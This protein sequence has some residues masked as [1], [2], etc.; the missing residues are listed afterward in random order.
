MA[1]SR[2][3]LADL[4]VF[5][6][7]ARNRS[8][9]RAGAE[10]GLS[11]SALSH[12]MRNLEGRLGVGLLNRNSRS[13]TPTHAG[14]ALLESLELG[15]QHIGDALE[16][17][18]QFREKPTG[19]LRLNVPRDAVDLLLRPVLP[20]YMRMYPEM[21]LEI[22]VDDNFVDIVAGGY[23]A[24][25]RH[26]GTVAE[27]MIAMN[28]GPLLRWI[29]VGAPGYLRQHG[30]PKMPED[31]REHSCIRMRCHEAIY[32]WEFEKDGDARIVDAP[33][34]LIVNDLDLAAHAAE[35]GGAWPTASSPR[36]PSSWRP[37]DCRRF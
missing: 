11:T 9:R 26:G 21:E 6:V 19:R 20:E 27:D 4:N 29:V 28:L 7:V 37:A 15:F 17:L 35:D 16:R 12:A 18:N 10:L 31:I 2:G 33:G 25:I 5:A 13:V 22:T 14:E 36:W 1:F 34:P 30:I 32:K 3:D 8:F 23:D 24:G